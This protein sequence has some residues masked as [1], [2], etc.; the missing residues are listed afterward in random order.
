MNRRYTEQ[1]ALSALPSLPRSLQ[2]NEVRHLSH[3]AHDRLGKS[4]VFGLIRPRKRLSDRLRLVPWHAHGRDRAEARALAIVPGQ[5][6]R[7]VQ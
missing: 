7:F 6:G 4:S 1:L 5:S 2:F 3:I